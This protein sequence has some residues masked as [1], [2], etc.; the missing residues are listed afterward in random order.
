MKIKCHNCGEE[1]EVK[2]LGRKPLDIPITD[3]YNAL[4][5]YRNV[6][7]AAAELGCSPAYIH[8]TLKNNGG[9]AAKDIIAGASA[10]VAE[11]NGDRLA[12]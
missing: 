8:A 12:S 5:K 3:I 10:A 4:T 1:I 9:G 7:L 6:S 2:G 11:A